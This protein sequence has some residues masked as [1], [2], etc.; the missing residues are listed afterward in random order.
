[1]N[2]EERT[3]LRKIIYA[4]E[5]GGQVY[6]QCDYGAFTEAYT[7]SSAEQAVTIGAGQWYADEA[8][9]LLRN[10]YVAGDQGFTD[11]LI[12]TLD[13]SWAYMQIREDSEL[14][15]TIVRVITTSIGKACQ[16]ALMDSQIDAYTMEAR[17]LDVTD[18][19]AQAMC[20]NW[21]HQGGLGAVVRL[22]QK[23]GKP[24]TLDRLYEACKSDTGNQVG[25]YRQRQ[26]FVFDE[27][28][29][30]FGVKTD[31]AREKADKACSIMEDWARDDSHGYDQIYR[32]GEKGDYD[33]SA[34]VIS[35]YE[36]AGVPVKSQRATYTGNMKEVFL[37]CGFKDVTDEVNLRTGSGLLR[38][39]A[40]LNEVHH[41]AMYCGDGK[42]VEASINEKG[43]ATGGKPGDQTGKEFLIRS[44][45]NYPWDCVLR[46]V[47]GG[48]DSFTSGERT[49]ITFTVEEVKLGDRCQSVWVLR[50]MLRGRG[51]KTADGTSLRRSR[52]F[53]ADCEYAV[54]FFQNKNG[55]DVDGIVGK[56]TWAKLT[57]L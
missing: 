47:G 25:A 31:S 1:M 35:A 9:R 15:K 34:A 33:C 5:T 20:V 54:R 22:L 26:K 39:D 14:A 16:D 49:K 52:T 41:T 44:Y 17:S 3:I 11:E 12:A 23:C 40:L 45:R 53:D 28:K 56:K 42:E 7:N 13:M 32:W 50:T 37:K 21:R 48:A 55:L 18:S 4:V 36:K 38:G 43:T 51:Y 46:Y 10:I 29:K 27:I 19:A 24:Y 30:R 6:G 2:V 57:A 8:V